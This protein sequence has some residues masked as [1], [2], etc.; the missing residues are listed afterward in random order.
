MYK[1]ACIEYS[2]CL[3]KQRKGDEHEVHVRLKMDG[4]KG[5]SGCVKVAVIKSGWYV[6]SCEKELDKR[7]NALHRA[8][9]V[10]SVK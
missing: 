2:E 7:E 10:Q 3:Y 1:V 4:I 9:N 5:S 8:K 6:G